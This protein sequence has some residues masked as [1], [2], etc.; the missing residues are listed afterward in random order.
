MEEEGFRG[1]AYLEIPGASHYDFPGAAD[2][3]RALE[4]LEAG[5]AADSTPE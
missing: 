2:L 4:A 5:P 1:V 3:R